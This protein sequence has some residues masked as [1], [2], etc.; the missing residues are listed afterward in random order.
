MALVLLIPGV[1]P[2]G[3]FDGYT[4]ETLNFKGGEIATWAAMP[5]PALGAQDVDNDGYVLP[6]G[7]GKE[8][9]GV[10]RALLTASSKPLFLT[11]DGILNYGTLFGL[12]VGGSVG[13]Q[14][15]GPLPS[16]I[17]G[18]ILGPHT[19]TGS[20]KITLWD[21]QG[22]YGT[23]LD[24]VDTAADGLV[25]SNGVIK[26]GTALTY[27]PGGANGGQLT[28]VGSTN[29]AGNT[30]VVARF[31][32]FETNGSLVTTPVSLVSALNSPSGSISSLA[33]LKFYQAV[34]WY[35]GAGAGA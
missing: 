18:A 30:T 6:T 10:S 7:L 23:T 33:Q 20:G 15:N 5:F 4:G 9:P 31:A 34:Y 27:V 19:A 24:A 28:P 16:Q 13:S 2:I 8:V 14:A 17:T 11:D 25:P 21:K 29:A 1:Q 12:V 32:E 26:V 3:V 22:L 35:N